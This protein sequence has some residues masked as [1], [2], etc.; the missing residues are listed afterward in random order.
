VAGKIRDDAYWEAKRAQVLQWEA[1][2]YAA[3]FVGCP[4]ISKHEQP[5]V[6]EPATLVVRSTLDCQR[7][8]ALADECQRLREEISKLRAKIRRLEGKP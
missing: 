3:S 1:D 7:A 4:H 5:T 6:G 2:S 8:N